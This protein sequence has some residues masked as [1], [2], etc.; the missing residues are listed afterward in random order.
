M[1]LSFET[2]MGETIRLIRPRYLEDKKVEEKVILARGS[3][4]NVKVMNVKTIR[5]AESI[6][7]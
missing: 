1:K 4:A 7:S 3:S 5:T 6:T 2:I